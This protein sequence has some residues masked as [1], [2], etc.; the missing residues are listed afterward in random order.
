MACTHFDDDDIVQRVVG[1]QQQLA[2]TDL[3][4]LVLGGGEQAIAVARGEQLREKGFG[5]R[6]AGTAGDR[7]DRS[8]KELPRSTGQ[9]HIGALRLVD[10]Q[11]GDSGHAPLGA[12]D[13]QHRGT[14]RNGLREEVVTVEAL[15]AQRQE[16]V[17]WF[18]RSRVGAHAQ[19]CRR[20]VAVKQRRIDRPNRNVQRKLHRGTPRAASAVRAA[21]ASSKGSTR[22]PTI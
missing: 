1:L 22:S 19:R 17:A 21:C 6:L 9:R 11:C 16:R 3:V 13:H 12:I 10:E 14:A 7:N 4:V 20:G 18:D 2:H 8:F 5:C 15:A